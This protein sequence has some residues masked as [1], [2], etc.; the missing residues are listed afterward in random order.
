MA[1]R[2]PHAAKKSTPGTN[3][4]SRWDRYLAGNPLALSRSRRKAP[5][6]RVTRFLE[7]DLWSAVRETVLGLPRETD[8]QLAVYGRTRWLFSLFFLGG[9]RIS[10]VVD[11]RMG[12]FFVRSDPKTGEQRWWLQVLGKGQKQRLVPAT[13]E[14]I[15]E[16]TAYRRSIG[17]KELPSPG[18]PSPLLLPISWHAG[19]HQPFSWPV[20]MTRSAIH[21]IV[22]HVFEV[23]ASRWVLDGRGQ[24]QADKLKAASSHWLRHTAGTSL[25]NEIEL[26]HVRDTLGHVSIATTSIYVVSVRPSQLDRS[27]WAGIQ[28]RQGG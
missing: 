2:R 7:E 3:A 27:A 26:H 16:L 19:Q 4:S 12:D 11:N 21:G 17:L 8:R 1:S 13:A 20:P 22:K 24:A 15:V 10:E 6:P 9:L 18:E 28:M 14:L 25:A 5:P 23:A